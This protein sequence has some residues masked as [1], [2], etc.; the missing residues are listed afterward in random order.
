[1]TTNDPGFCPRPG[2]ALA[3]VDACRTSV[4]FTP[5]ALR[6]V[7]LPSCLVTPEPG[8]RRAHK[9]SMATDRIRTTVRG[10]S[11]RSRNPSSIRPPRWALFRKMTVR[12]AAVRQMAAG[13]FGACGR[14][15][16]ISLERGPGK[17][18]VGRR[19]GVGRGWDVRWVAVVGT[20][21]PGCGPGEAENAS[22]DAPFKVSP[23]IGISPFRH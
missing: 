22:A 11:E 14:G 5:G 19:E 9:R 12:N 6:G 7:N 21:D 23:S 13:A 15:P 20:D 8:T 16:N 4:R 10:G 18:S 3:P 2:R 17:R 1:M